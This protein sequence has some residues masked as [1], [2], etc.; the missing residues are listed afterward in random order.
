MPR[1][2]SDFTSTIIFRFGIFILFIGV[3]MYE[4]KHL[5][6]LNTFYFSFTLLFFCVVTLVNEIQ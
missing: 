5:F 1:I 4:S 2:T 6:F 3:M